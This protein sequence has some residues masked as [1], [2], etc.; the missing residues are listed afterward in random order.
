MNKVVP[1]LLDSVGEPEERRVKK[2][3]PLGIQAS[4]KA[5]RFEERPAQSNY[6]MTNPFRALFNDNA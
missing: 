5:R 2:L 4:I 6:A 1:V 3:F